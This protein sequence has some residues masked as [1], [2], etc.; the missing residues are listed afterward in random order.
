M[1]VL[2]AAPGVPT[3]ARLSADQVKEHLVAAA[4]AMATGPR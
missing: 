1:Q 4:L 3:V 2:E